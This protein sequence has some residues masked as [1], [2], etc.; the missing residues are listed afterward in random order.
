[1]SAT[2]GLRIGFLELRLPAR[3]A[4]VDLKLVAVRARQKLALSV[5]RRFGAAVIVGTGVRLV[6]GGGD[7]RRVHR[8]LCGERVG[9]L[10]GFLK[11]PHIAAGGGDEGRIDEERLRRRLRRL[12]AQSRRDGDESVFR[13]QNRAPSHQHRIA[14]QIDDRRKPDRRFRSCDRAWG[15][16]RR[17]RR[18]LR[19]RRRQSPRD[20]AC[21]D[22]SDQDRR[23]QTDDAAPTAHGK[24]K[25][26]PPRPASLRLKFGWSGQRAPIIR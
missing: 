3:S 8:Q 9:L 24:L 25:S 2:R 19:S 6:L 10:A 7:L 12:L 5:S 20:K 13:R 15:D 17:G 14:R 16:R 21:A 26:L 4:E 22:A 18:R 11:F 1:M 23:S